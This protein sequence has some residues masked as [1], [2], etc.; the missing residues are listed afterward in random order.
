MGAA[1]HP[2]KLRARRI[3]NLTEE[4]N[5]LTKRISDAVTSSTPGLLDV[6]GIGPDSAAALR[7]TVG[8]NPERLGSEASFATPYQARIRCHQRP[9]LAA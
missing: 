6:N 4:I 1:R 7:I 9:D 3:L 8:D 5:D 2:L